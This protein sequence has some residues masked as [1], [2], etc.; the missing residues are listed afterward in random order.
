VFLNNKTAYMMLCPVINT[1]KTGVY[2]FEDLI[3]NNSKS[4]EYKYFYFLKGV[5]SF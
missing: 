3:K 4:G 2:V 1:V 5:E